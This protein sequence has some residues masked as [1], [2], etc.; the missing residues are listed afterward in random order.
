MNK[1]NSFMAANAA[2]AEVTASLRA[3]AD[4]TRGAAEPDR[5][6]KE[7]AGVP[8]GVR[9]MFIARACSSRGERKNHEAPRSDGSAERRTTDRQKRAIPTAAGAAHSDGPGGS[10]AAVRVHRD[11]HR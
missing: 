4:P 2:L 5:T 8:H 3:L 10:Q 1:K 9:K 11:Q 7:A 6:R